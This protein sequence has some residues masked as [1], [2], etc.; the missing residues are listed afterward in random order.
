MTMK[1]SLRIIITLVAHYDLDWQLNEC[2][3]CLFK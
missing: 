2:K 1:D 3:N